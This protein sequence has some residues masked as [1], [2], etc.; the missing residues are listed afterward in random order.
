[1]SASSITSVSN[2]NR[3]FP[4]PP[5]FAEHAHVKSRAEYDALYQQSIDDPERFW[6]ERARE[7]HWF[8][9]PQAHARVEARRSRSGSPGGTINVTYNCLDRH[10]H[11]A[12]RNK[13][14]IIWE[15]EPGDTRTLTYQQLH[16]EVCRFANA[17][18][19]LGVGKGDRVAIY[20]G[21]VPEAAIAMLACA[22]IGAVHSVVFG[23]FAADA[24]R[25]RMN[26]AKAKCVITQDGAFRRGAALAAQAAGRQGARGVPE[27]RA[28]D[29]AAPRR[30]TRSR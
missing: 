2:E 9:P 7:L 27:R 13:A 10:L 3:V 19:K 29:R 26:D 4:P 24:L 28:R 25:D 8:T 6:A 20:M 21:M 5:A 12:T 14:A 18:E 17:L 23:G 16:R 30:A 15:G 1:M 11:G 22:R